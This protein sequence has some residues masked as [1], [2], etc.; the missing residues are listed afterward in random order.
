MASNTPAPPSDGDWER[1]VEHFRSDRKK[2][3]ELAADESTDLFGKI[4]HGDGQT[5]A[6]EV[7]LIADTMF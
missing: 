4:P 1:G 2:M 5:I 3:C 7:L 6:L